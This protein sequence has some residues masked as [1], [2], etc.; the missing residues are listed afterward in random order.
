MSKINPF[1][2]GII[3]F[4][5]LVIVGGIVFAYT[6]ADKTPKTYSAESPD[7]PKAELSASFADLG[8]MKVSEIKTLDFFLK[9]TGNQNLEINNIS[10]SCD[11]TFAQ[12]T[13]GDKISPRF[14][15]HQNP[16]WMG[17]IE[18]GREAKVTASYE[19][20]RM[21]VKGKVERSVYIRTNDPQKPDIVLTLVAEVN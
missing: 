20:A 10:T 9:N 16:N 4:L 6:T 17:Q 13:I 2:L 15:M 18:P 7:R 5:V 12:I 8:Q 14:S 1:I 11:C 3:I 19:P 21:P